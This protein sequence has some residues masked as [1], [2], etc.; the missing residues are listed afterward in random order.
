MVFLVNVSFFFLPPSVVDASGRKSWSWSWPRLF[1]SAPPPTLL[2][3]QSSS[4][5]S[6]SS[7]CKG[8]GPKIDEQPLKQENDPVNSHTSSTTQPHHSP[9]KDIIHQ[10]LVNPALFDPVRTP[11]FPIVLCHGTIKFSF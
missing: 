7:S 4:S 1:P 3:T 8:E 2:Q 9:S 6:L 10:L 11:R 5:S